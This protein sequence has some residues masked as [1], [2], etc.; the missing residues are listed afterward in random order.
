MAR[1]S[2]EAHSFPSATCRAQADA[3]VSPALQRMM[4]ADPPA[5][6]SEVPNAATAQPFKV[7][8]PGQAGPVSVELSASLDK[9]V[10]K[11]DGY[12]TVT[13]TAEVAASASG[14]LDLKKVSI[15][16]GVSKSNTQTYEV[17]LKDADFEKLKKGEIP[18]PHPLKPETLPEGSSVT[19]DT[20]QL[21]GK[22]YEVSGE[23][24][25]VS[26]GLGEEIKKGRGLSI[27]A[28]RKGD[29]VTLTAGPTELL[30]SNP[31][32]TVGVDG[33]SVNF[34][35]NTSLKDYKLR[36]ATFDVKSKAGKDAFEKFAKTKQLP[37]QNGNGVSGVAT[38]EK[39]DLNSNLSA[40]AKLGSFSKIVDVVPESSFSF[41]TTNLSGRLAGHLAG[42]AALFRLHYRV[43]ESRRPGREGGRLQA[44][45]LHVHE[46]PG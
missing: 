28:E 13:L 38:V 1:E 39:L 42:V 12:T 16:G 43:Q 32:I 31:A 22:S 33:A 15:G 14:T 17:K 11:K 8:L 44:G 35:S 34:T 2:S 10:K 9:N 3:R 24:F 5:V 18:P 45:V 26:L 27:Q 20:S 37:T 23:Q 36:T 40:E 19:M 30:E 46:G 29:D 4:V 21:T 6:P 7:K 25:G 41:T